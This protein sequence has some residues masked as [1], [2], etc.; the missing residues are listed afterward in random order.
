[1]ELNGKQKSYLR[2]LAQTM[3]PI[4]QVG[5]DGIDATFLVNVR[6]YLVKHEL[7]KV[8]LLQSNPLEIEEVK[9]QFEQQGFHIVQEIGNQFVLYKRNPKLKDSIQLPR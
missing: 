1:M 9:V 7:V 6:D 3:K 5:K 4:F 8:T 2:S